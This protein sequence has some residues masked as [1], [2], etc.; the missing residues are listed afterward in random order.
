MFIIANTI[1]LQNYSCILYKLNKELDVFAKSTVFSSFNIV[2]GV[3]LS[4]SQ[5][6]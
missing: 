5:I 1:K 2:N 3:L 6:N 4:C